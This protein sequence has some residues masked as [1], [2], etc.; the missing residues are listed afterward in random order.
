M[1]LLV[2]LPFLLAR[3]PG[4]PRG[5]L[6]G[7]LF[8]QGVTSTALPWLL[9]TWA[10][11][12]IDSALATV[13]NGTVPLST[14]VFA[15]FFLRDD[16]MTRARIG[17]LMVGFVGIIFLVQKDLRLF[18][19][20]DVGVGI[21]LAAQGAMLLS[22]LSYGASNV[23]ARA[24]LHHVPA[25]FQ[26]FYTMLVADVAMWTITPAVEGLHLPASPLAWAAIVWLGVLGAGV[27]YLIFYRLLHEIGP[28]RIATVTYTIP[29][30]GVSLSVIVLGERL[31]WSLLVGTILIV[32]GVRVVT[33]R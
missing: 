18:V 3:R 6:W 1:A 30:V 28:T 32:A 19:S 2:L 4:L 8:L 13:L 7:V 12:Y 11:K 26:A 10:E 29:V 16:R 5:R 9:I 15:H 23:Y 22:A 27:S 21:Q 31:D 20:D 14:V 17:G 33:R 25:V 24:K